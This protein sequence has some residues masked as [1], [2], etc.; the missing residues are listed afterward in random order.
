MSVTEGKFMKERLINKRR[1]MM[2][3][4]AAAMVLSL[5]TPA[6]GVPEASADEAAGKITVEVIANNGSGCAAGTASVL[7]NADDT[8]FRVRYRDF[9][10]KAGGDA[11]V[12][13]RRK[14]CQLS[15]L[16]TLPDGW[17]VAIAAANYRGRASL[18]SGASGLQRTSYYW[19][20]SSE[21]HRSDLPLAG[22][23][24]GTWATWDVAPVLLYAPCTTRRVLNVNTELRVDAGD[25]AGG[26]SLSMSA[27][28]GD[29]ETLFN[30]SW[31]RC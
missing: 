31:S 23:L 7:S 9:V 14:N 29:V 28:E 21:S 20:G 15:V 13:D 25:S 26:N 10:A 18:Q 12:V 6:Y 3:V 19:Q 11:S 4:L 24:Y 27:T 22:P 30:L 1:A 16:V 2:T 5:G 17:T 8:G